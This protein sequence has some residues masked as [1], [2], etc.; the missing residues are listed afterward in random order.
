MVGDDRRGR[1][2]VDDLVVSFQLTGRVQIIPKLLQNDLVD[3]YRAADLLVL[4][5]FEEGFGLPI[6]EAMACGTPVICSN[7]AS[8]PEVGGEAASYFNPHSAE[9]IAYTIAAVLDSPEK[10]ERMARSGIQR[11]ARFTWEKSFQSHYNVYR[12]FV[13]QAAAAVPLAS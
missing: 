5:S 4:P 2:S 11:A 6:I 8:M 12:E 10:R 1:A 7:C 3:F 9:E 13:P